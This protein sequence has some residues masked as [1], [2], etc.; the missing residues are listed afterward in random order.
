MRSP[1]MEAGLRFRPQNL[2]RLAGLMA[3]GGFCILLIDI[4]SLTNRILSIK[5]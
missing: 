2:W 5:L 4:L 1:A 3:L